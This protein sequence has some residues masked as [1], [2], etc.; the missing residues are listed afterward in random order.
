VP[1]RNAV[2]A[3]FRD[4]KADAVLRKRTVASTTLSL[5]FL[6]SLPFIAVVAR[7]WF[8]EQ[9]DAGRTRTATQKQQRRKVREVVFEKR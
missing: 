5:P 3:V 2:V 9:K 4:N 1:T 8:E 7:A 6:R